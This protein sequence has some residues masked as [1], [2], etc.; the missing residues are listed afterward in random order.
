MKT[1]DTLNRISLLEEIT[2][3][4][5]TIEAINEA[6]EGTNLVG[7]FNS[8]GEMFAHIDHDSNE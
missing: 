4:Q 5:D 7:P 2:S 1:N 8:V 3:N 6:Y